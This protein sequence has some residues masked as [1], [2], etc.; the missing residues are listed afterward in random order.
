M[1]SIQYIRSYT[2]KE[3]GPEERNTTLQ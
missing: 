2:Q 3:N 1:E